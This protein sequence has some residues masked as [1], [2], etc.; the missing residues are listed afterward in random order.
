MHWCNRLDCARIGYRNKQGNKAMKKDIL[1]SE[2][3]KS[4]NT[5]TSGEPEFWALLDYY[6]QKIEENNYTE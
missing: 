3:V 6:V 5:F 2:I 1:I 4:V